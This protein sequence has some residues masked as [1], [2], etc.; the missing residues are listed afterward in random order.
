MPTTIPTTTSSTRPG[1][2]S[3]GD[4]YFETDT[5]N[6][7]IYDGA[8]WRGFVSDGETLGANGY[9]LDLDGTDDRV[10][11]GNISSLN[12]ASAFSI[13]LWV[14][15]L[16]SA[17][18]PTYFY[19]S[20]TDTFYNSISFYQSTSLDFLMG[21]G[22][23]SYAGTRYSASIKDN[24][25]HHLVGVF[26]G[27]TMTIYLDGSVPTQ[28][29]I[30]SSI[31]SSTLSTGG[32][33]PHI[34]SKTDNTSELEGKMDDFSIFNA[35]LT[36]TEVANIYN[37]RLYNPTKLIHQYRFENNYNDSKG[38]LNGTAQGN[39]TFDSSDKPY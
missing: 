1:S 21:L 30:G 33:N 20:G 35:A 38:S 6:Y 28:S 32:S 11:L 37:S 34:G 22:G 24:S 16:S 2:P 23:S 39:P 7:I 36:A 9:S 13:S 15:V 8:A 14:K 29:G 25:W 27:S 5:K 10:E 31:P 26:N 4:A 12:S 3:A 19:Q 18:S 17:P